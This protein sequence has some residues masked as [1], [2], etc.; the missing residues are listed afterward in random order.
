MAS[1]KIVHFKSKKYS[2]GTSP[3][4]LRV[5]INRVINY[6]TLGDTF[7]CKYYPD[8]NG[9]PDPRYKWNEP[10]MQFNSNFPNFKPSNRNLHNRLA[11]AEGILIEL[12]NEK[13]NYG[14]DDFRQKFVKKDERIFLLAYLDSLIDRFRSTA[15][16]GNMMVYQSCRNVFND[17]LK[18]DVQM[19]AITP[20]LLNQFIEFCQIRGL[21]KNSTSNYLRTLR[22]ACN[23][24]IKEE[25]LKYYPF[26]NFDRW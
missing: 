13:I 19:T 1:V 4:L 16:I 9:N 10:A 23:T 21:K 15:R 22:A 6:Y 2:D 11:E 26:E 12:E 24:A 3:V 18:E 25:G 14:H 8:I 5:I 17:F 20:K 7:K